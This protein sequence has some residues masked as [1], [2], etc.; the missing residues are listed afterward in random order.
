MM[1]SIRRQAFCPAFTCAA[2]LLAFSV[3]T[4]L[5]AGS[6]N[7]SFDEGQVVSRD[8]MMRALPAEE[9]HP[10]PR[11][12]INAREEQ[13]SCQP[14]N[15]TLL[16]VHYRATPTT[17]SG[18][19]D[20]AIVIAAPENNKYQIL[21]ILDSDAGI[22]NGELYSEN[23]FEQDFISINGLRFLYVRNRISGS[24]GITEHA[25]YTISSDNI[26]STIPFADVSKSNVL[27]APEELRNGQLEF[28]GS[29][30]RYSAGIY[31]PKDP[32]CCPSD[33]FYHAEFRLR[34]NFKENPVN[35]NFTPDFQ[36]V[37]AREWRS[38]D[39]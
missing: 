7:T 24:G 11:A 26:V 38:A 3:V 21:K 23:D 15:K 6:Q 12:V 5:D 25:V 13:I 20:D 17:K 22:V 1:D 39:R 16:S 35:H 36:F 19:N 9:D 10:F 33:G 8:V 27:N 28:Y 32:E 2:L 34:G 4:S 29:G 18:M 14:N 30:F 31:K 37:V